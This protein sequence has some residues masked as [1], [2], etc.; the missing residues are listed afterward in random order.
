MRA[1]NDIARP[2]S[3]FRNWTP[4]LAASQ[5]RAVQRHEAALNHQQPLLSWAVSISLSTRWRTDKESAFLPVA[6][7]ETWANSWPHPLPRYSQA[8]GTFLASSLGFNFFFFSF[9]LFSSFFSPPFG[10]QRVTT[11]KVYNHAACPPPLRGSSQ[12]VGVPTCRSIVSSSPHIVAHNDV[13]NETRQQGPAC[14]RPQQL[15]RRTERLPDQE[16]WRGPRRQAATAREREEIRRRCPG[17]PAVGQSEK[18]E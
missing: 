7:L 1:E 10:C 18:G 9:F 17:R 15:C 6:R 4:G 8:Q 16:G 5:P 11:P 12:L 3:H 14:A 2:L 13:D